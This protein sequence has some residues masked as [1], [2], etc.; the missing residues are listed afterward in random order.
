MHHAKTFTGF[1]AVTPTPDLAATLE[2]GQVFRWRFFTDNEADAAAKAFS[3]QQRSSSVYAPEAWWYWGT[4]GRQP[5]ALCQAEGGLVFCCIAGEEEALFQ[6][7]QSYF[8]L[9]DDLELVYRETAIDT[10]V[11]EALGRHR[12]LR[13]LRQD[14]WECLVSFVCSSVSNIPRIGRTVEAMARRYGEAVTLAGRQ[15]YTFP[16]PERLGCAG[17]TE[18]R[19]LGLGFRSKYVAQIASAVAA[20]GI[21]IAGLRQASYQEAKSALLA[22]PGVGDKVAECILLFALDKQ[23]GFPIDRWVRRS[24]AAWYFPDQRMNDAALRSWA[25]ERWGRYAG[26]VQQYLFHDARITGRRKG[27]GS[28]L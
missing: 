19:R 13:L 26:Y 5:V 23:E 20:G 3:R 6:A 14:P 4:V 21:D 12:G 27:L 2:G 10:R 8:R 22:L 25:Q 18:L 15:L 28:Q 1:L 17:E 9:E 16:D 24:L 7:L 11:A